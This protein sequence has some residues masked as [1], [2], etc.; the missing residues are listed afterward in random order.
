[1]KRSPLSPSTNPRRLALRLGGAL[2]GA[3][4]VAGAVFP[5]SAG[6]TARASQVTPIASCPSASSVSAAAGYSVP[7]ATQSST[8]NTGSSAQFGSL[9]ETTTICFY[10]TPSLQN[11]H[12]IEIVFGKLSKSIPEAQVK[13]YLQA[14]AGKTNK[15]LPGGGTFSFTF[16]TLNGV[17]VVWMSG[18]A[19]VESFTFKFNATYGYKGGKLA[20]AAG[21][22]TSKTKVNALAELA[23]SKFGI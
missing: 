19:T 15:A 23:F 22:N 11:M 13:A 8:T 2:T 12:F 5:A 9:T 7:A 16:G 14:Q 21:L 4:L 1:M 17:P 10:G 6:A 20:G 18:G 3:V